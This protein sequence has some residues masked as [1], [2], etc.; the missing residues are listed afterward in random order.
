MLLEKELQE[1]VT[2]KVPV[3]VIT[4]NGFQMAGR[5]LDADSS[6]VAIDCGGCT[7]GCQYER[8][9]HYRDHEGLRRVYKCL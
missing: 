2:R 7:E 3:R 8:H 5:L 1:L 4:I 9:L 6:A